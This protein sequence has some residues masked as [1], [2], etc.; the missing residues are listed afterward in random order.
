MYTC[1]SSKEVKTLTGSL[2]TKTLADGKEYYYMVL[3]FYDKHTGKR[4]PKWFPTGLCVKGNK[5]QA[6]QMLLDTLAKYP[7]RSYDATA[8]T[9]FSDW[10]QMW[11]D[12][13][14]TYVRTST[15]PMVRGIKKQEN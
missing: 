4:T 12:S 10:G 9:L 5:R 14:K 11:L 6:E 7:N 2:Q 3:N 13:A 1:P 15:L 8:D